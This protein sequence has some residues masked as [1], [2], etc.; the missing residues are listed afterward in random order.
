MNN[1]LEQL[2]TF[3]QQGGSPQQL[4]NQIADK[5]PMLKNVINMAQNGDNQ[6]IE[7]F[8]RNMFKEQGRDF[9]K[10]FADFMK[11]FK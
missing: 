11:N 9:D 8:A 4:V 2:K 10:E 3:I 6:N 5:N 1:Y 7:T